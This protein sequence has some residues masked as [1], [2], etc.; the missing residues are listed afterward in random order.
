MAMHFRSL[1]TTTRRYMREEFES[2][3]ASGKVYLSRRFNDVG[4][5]RYP[6]LAFSLPLT[7]ETRSRWQTA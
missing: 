3:Q 4:K 1:D 5:A 6:P 7:T 2:D